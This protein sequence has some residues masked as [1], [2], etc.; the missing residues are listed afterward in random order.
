R[1]AAGRA[2][3]ALGRALATRAGARPFPGAR[4]ALAEPRG[5]PPPPRLRRSGGRATRESP[6]ARAFR[7][8]PPSPC[9][10][11]PG[12]VVESL[13]AD[14]RRAHRPP[15]GASPRAGESRAPPSRQ[16]EG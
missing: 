16:A 11:G 10:A 5:S 4:G 3:R 1:L 12:G 14:R 2:P 8:S 7:R 6:L 15:A 9:P 13:E